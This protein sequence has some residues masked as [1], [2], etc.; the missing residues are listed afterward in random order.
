MP[1]VML[2]AL[3]TCGFCQRTRQFLDEHG[4]AYDCVYVDEARGVERERVL[5]EAARWNPRVTF[6]TIVVDERAVVVGFHEEQLREAL[7]L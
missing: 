4:V 6:P 2:F 3:T 1:K 7:G 5:A